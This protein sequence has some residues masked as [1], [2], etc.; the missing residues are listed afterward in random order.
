MTSL[1]VI[2]DIGH[3][4]WEIISLFLLQYVDQHIIAICCWVGGAIYLV[5]FG[6]YA[7]KALDNEPRE[8]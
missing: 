4:G 2:I 5:S 3:W 7:A 1:N 6:R 8:K